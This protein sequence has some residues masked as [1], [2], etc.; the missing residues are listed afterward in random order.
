M[1]KANVVPHHIVELTK[2]LIEIHRKWIIDGADAAA[3]IKNEQAGLSEQQAAVHE[4]AA[5][6]G[7]SDSVRSNLCTA[8]R[9]FLVGGLTGDGDG[10]LVENV[11][12]DVYRAFAVRLS[13]VIAAGGDLRDVFASFLDIVCEL[14]A[15]LDRLGTEPELLAIIKR[16]RDP[17]DDA[18]M[19][20]MLREY[21]AR[22]TVRRRQ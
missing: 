9:Q 20:I 19:L 22:A 8:T 12:E 13:D 6:R 4:F 14:Y 3:D 18:E 17:L 1:E 15:A 10:P 7:L 2:R 11:S 21:N 5:R 16:W